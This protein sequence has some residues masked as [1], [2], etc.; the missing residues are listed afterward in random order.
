MCE[1]FYVLFNSSSPSSPRC[2]V[3]F[4]PQPISLDLPTSCPVSLPNSLTYT[5]SIYL[6]IQAPFQSSTHVP[7]NLLIHPTQAYCPSLQF[8]LS[9]HPWSMP[10]PTKMPSRC[11][12]RLNVYTRSYSTTR[13]PP[14]GDHQS[15]TPNAHHTNVPR[16]RVSFTRSWKRSM[17]RA[18]SLPA[19]RGSHSRDLPTSRQAHLQA[20]NH[21][22]NRDFSPRSNCPT[23]PLA[24]ESSA[25]AWVTSG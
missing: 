24:S 7:I 20:S 22:R 8:H 16:H 5:P 14:A 15:S 19:A 21:T 3:H 10:L 6:S 4:I 2:I 23:W 17:S 13:T 25:S 18:V 9:D 11:R 12:L 1:A